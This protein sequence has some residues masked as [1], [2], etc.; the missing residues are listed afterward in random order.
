MKYRTVRPFSGFLILTL[1]QIVLPN[2]TSAANETFPSGAFIINTGV[3]P[4]TAA[5]GLKPY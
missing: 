4:Q 3:T 5:N 1:L 2:T